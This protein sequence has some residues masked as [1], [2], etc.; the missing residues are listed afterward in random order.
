LSVIF[1]KLAT[2]IDAILEEF[3]NTKVG[4]RSATTNTVEQI[5]GESQALLHNLL[6]IM[7]L[8]LTEY[9]FDQACYGIELELLRGSTHLK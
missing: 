1:S 8:I 4:N 3:Y 5:I 9:R 7:L 2:L 6:E